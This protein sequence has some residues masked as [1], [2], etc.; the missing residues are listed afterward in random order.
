MSSMGRSLGG[1][2]RVQTGVTR[3]AIVQV[4]RQSPMTVQQLA[5]RLGL[6][7]SSV[8]FHLVRLVH[9]GLVSEDQAVHSGPG[10]PRLVYSPAT[11]PSPHSGSGQELLARALADH[12]AHVVPSPVDFATAAG[13]ERGRQLAAQA[14]HPGP[15]SEDE[16]EEEITA[17]MR[18]TGFDPEWDADGR[19][20]WL[21]NC[22]FRPLA[23]EQPAVA[24]SVHLGLM[25]G[26]LE[27]LDAPLDVASLDA[28]PAP[29]ACMTTFVLRG[30]APLAHGPTLH[31]AGG[32]SVRKFV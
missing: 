6:H 27:T 26:V 18:D 2:K 14:A 20:L 28:F 19:R 12:L 31:R 1:S 8:R 32:G 10:R 5:E 16:A 17:I 3:N 7:H 21:R 11:A 13:V 15:V 22:P 25:R 23:A 30:E 29:H 24:C 4:L 9:A